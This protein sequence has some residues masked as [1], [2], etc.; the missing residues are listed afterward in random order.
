MDTYFRI[1]SYALVTMAFLALAL[2]GELEAWSIALFVLAVGTSIYREVRLR[3]S[4][5]AGVDVLLRGARRARAR[6]WLW[7]TVIVLYIPF[8]FADAFIFS[9]R[10]LALTHLT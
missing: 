3:N 1:T 8:L 5:R 9:N 10:I 4:S 6:R 7:R 2:T